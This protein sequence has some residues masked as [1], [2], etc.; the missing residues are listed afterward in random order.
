MLRRSIV[1]TSLY[2]VY[3]PM[4]KRRPVSPG[5]LYEHVKQH[6]LTH[7][8]NGDW[9]VGTRLPSEHELVAQ[10]GVSRMTVHRAL[11]ELSAKGL[12]QRMVGVGT[13]VA[14]PTQRSPLIEVRDIAD[15]IVARGHR[16]SLRLIKI[17][18]IRANSELAAVLQ[19]KPNA[20]IFHSLV[21]H[22][23]EGIAVQLEERFVT[24]LFAPDYLQQDFANITTTH[25]LQGIA[26]PTEVANAVYAIRPDARIC[27]LL[28][29]EASEPCLQMTRQTWV[30]SDP[31]T[32]NI[33]TYPGSRYSLASRYKVSEAPER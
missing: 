33:F 2:Y 7:I 17:G 21:V 9:P 19:Q 12:V 22:F 27:K 24:P 28:N 10:F 18:V 3:I 26:A 8:H 11:R 20:R 31:A 32:N 23:E 14:T 30:N 4:T 13:F 6:I 16:H 15:D 1:Y 25:Y 29:T 5:P